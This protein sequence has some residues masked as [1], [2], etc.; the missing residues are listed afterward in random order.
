LASFQSPAPIPTAVSVIGLV[1]GTAG[2]AASD[3]AGPRREQPEPART[4]EP[5]PAV[6]FAPGLLT[7]L[8]PHAVIFKR[9]AL[10]LSVIELKQNNS[11]DWDW[12]PAL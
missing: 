8:E 5:L 10:D 11:I 7:L 6:D 1:S 3:T 9:E 12:W 2:A 4:A